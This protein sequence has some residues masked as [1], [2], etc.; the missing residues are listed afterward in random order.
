[1]C[2][3]MKEKIG[4]KIIKQVIRINW[5]ILQRP[6]SKERERSQAASLSEEHLHLAAIH[7]V[8]CGKCMCTA[9]HCL[10]LPCLSHPLHRAAKVSWPHVTTK[11]NVWLS[12]LN[13][14]IHLPCSKSWYWRI[15]NCMHKFLFAYAVMYVFEWISGEIVGVLSLLSWIF[16]F[17]FYF[18][19]LDYKFKFRHHSCNQYFIIP[20]LCG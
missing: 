19:R 4:S 3:R 5:G 2:I 10:L 18:Q 17:F 16:F 20:Q 8:L 14:H 7:S 15:Q 9:L 11:W 6:W 1:M 12:F 13:K